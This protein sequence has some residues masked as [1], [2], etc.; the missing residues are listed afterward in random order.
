MDSN[1]LYGITI[2]GKE[3]KDLNVLKDMLQLLRTHNKLKSVSFAYVEAQTSL[4]PHLSLWENLQIV[5]G[6]QS[7]KESYHVMDKEG[8]ALMNLIKNPHLL[9][10]E[11]EPWERF[12]ISLLKG[13]STPCKTLLIDFN[14]D[15]MPA[16]MIQNLKKTFLKI[17]E[18]KSI[19]LASASTSLW[20]D[21]AHSLVTRNKFEF[22][23]ETFDQ[24]N[25]K[26]HWAA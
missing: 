19:Y 26:R 16:F 21:C 10:Q 11:A 25:I 14:E 17:T 12:L 5:T 3:K 15:L 23:V 24:D 13:L 18:Q 6:S 4:I 2:Y 9:A 22:D 7:W 20:F 8:V 1:K